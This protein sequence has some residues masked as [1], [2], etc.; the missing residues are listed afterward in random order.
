MQDFV[1]LVAEVG[2]SHADTDL[3]RMATSLDREDPQHGARRDLDALRPHQLAV[4][5][6]RTVRR[7]EAQRDVASERVD[8]VLPEQGAPGEH[9]RQ[10]RT[11]ERRP[12]GGR[13]QVK[14]S[15]AS[16]AR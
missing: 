12:E 2:L 8:A 4:E 14:R 9:E 16:P 3:A 10:L 5:D 11:E 6:I 1:T 15:R 13:D 7:R